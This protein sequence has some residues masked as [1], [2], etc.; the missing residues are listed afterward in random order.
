M[1]LVKLLFPF[2]V[3]SSVKELMRGP[4]FPNMVSNTLHIAFCLTTWNGLPGGTKLLRSCLSWGPAPPGSSSDHT[5][6]TPFGG[7]QGFPP[8]VTPGSLNSLFPSPRPCISEAREWSHS[9]D[10]SWIPQRLARGWCSK[11]RKSLQHPQT[12]VHTDKVDLLPSE[13]M[14]AVGR[15]ASR[16]SGWLRVFPWAVVPANITTTPGPGIR[17]G[18]L[19][20]GKAK[21]KQA[22]ECAKLAF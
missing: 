4:G 5:I 8:R 6:L 13:G 14:R 20:A 22:L 2:L 18:L 3:P 9:P 21:H 12:P 15:V 11:T 1:L 16:L 17:G 19:N 10:H 7:S